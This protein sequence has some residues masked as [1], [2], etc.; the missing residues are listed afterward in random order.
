MQLNALRYRTVGPYICVYA[1]PT[2]SEE[3]F[4]IA[5]E[6]KRTRR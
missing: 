3:E 6:L 2:I 5:D 1:H 4:F